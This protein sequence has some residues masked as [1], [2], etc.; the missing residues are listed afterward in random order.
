MPE[1]HIWQL[2][3]MRQ[4]IS[5][6]YPRSTLGY[7]GTRDVMMQAS[8][9]LLGFTLGLGVSSAFFAIALWLSM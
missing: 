4:D 2:K 1:R 6:T 9:V 8:G 7:V 5:E 3:A